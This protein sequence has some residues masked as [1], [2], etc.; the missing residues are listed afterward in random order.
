MNSS[1]FPTRII[2][3]LSNSS[4][5]LEWY[6]KSDC[7]DSP[8]ELCSE[9]CDMASIQSSGTWAG[10]SCLFVPQNF[11]PVEFQIRDAVNRK[12]ETILAQVH[13]LRYDRGYRQ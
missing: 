3:F 12:G 13:C 8:L 5:D 11:V 9:D 6:S 1:S 4:S 2:C 7:N 10:V